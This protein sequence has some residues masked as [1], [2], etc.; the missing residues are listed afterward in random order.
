MGSSQSK[1][2]SKYY[3][4]K[5]YPTHTFTGKTVCKECKKA[6]HYEIESLGYPS[7]RQVKIYWYLG[8]S[9]DKIWP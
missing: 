5:Y 3:P 7:A 9:C 6:Y 1:N 8:G 2:Q 4:T